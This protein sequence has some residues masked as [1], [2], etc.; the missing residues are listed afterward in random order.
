MRASLPK[1]LH[2]VAGESMLAHVL[3]AAPS[4]DGARLAV[5][6]GPEHAAVETEAKRLRPDVDIFI[7]R[8]RLGTAHAVLAARASRSAI[9]RCSL[10]SMRR[11]FA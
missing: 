2:P 9:S 10:A 11:A 1:V 8:E 7:Q 3:A 5:V 4:G 6:L